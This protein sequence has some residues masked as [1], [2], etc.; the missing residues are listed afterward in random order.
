MLTK[1]RAILIFLLITIPLYSLTPEE[2]LKAS[3]GKLYPEIMTYRLTIETSNENGRQTKDVMSGY[4]K[5]NAHNVL[6]T[7]EPKRY[8]GTVHL[9]KDSVIWSYFSTNRKLAKFSYKAIFMGTVLNYGDVF[10]TELSYDYGIDSLSEDDSNYCV[11]M[12]IREDHEGYA[13]IN[14]IVDK[15]TLLPV[16]KEYFAL[17]GITNKISNFKEIKYD[18]KGIL[19]KMVIEFIEPIKQRTSVVTIDDTK[20]VNDIP[21]KYFNENY[22]KFLGGE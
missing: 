18:E 22:L 15:T 7:I 4:R 13:K 11:A 17:S 20:V 6:L 3:D 14:L 8:Q 1:I 16:R 19:T 21:E 12:K 5:G 9:R 10:A 2:I